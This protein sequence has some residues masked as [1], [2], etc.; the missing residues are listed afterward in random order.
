[1]KVSAKGVVTKIR[2]IQNLPNILVRFTLKCNDQSFN[3]VVANKDIVNRVLMFPN[4]TN[5]VAI[6][7]HMNNRKQL[8]V[9]KLTTQDTVSYYRKGA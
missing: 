6:Y 9:E 3:C 8:V 2:V 1:M 4:E 7:G 5:G